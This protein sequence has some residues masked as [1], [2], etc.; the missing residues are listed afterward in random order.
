[1]GWWVVAHVIIVSAPVQRI[2]FL[3]FLDLGS[4]F[5]ACWEWDRGLG[6]WTRAWQFEQHIVKG[7]WQTF[8]AVPSCRVLVIWMKWRMQYLCPELI[9]CVECRNVI[10][11]VFSRAGFNQ[12]SLWS[13]KMN[14][15]TSCPTITILED[16]NCLFRSNN[17][18]HPFTQSCNFIN[19]T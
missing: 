2:G 18:Y 13:N 4:G 6:T 16:G 5:G 11:S 3:G 19:L 10:F 1:M 9:C 17:V 15:I 8:S 12:S 14:R 7:S